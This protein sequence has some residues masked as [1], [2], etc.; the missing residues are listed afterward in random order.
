[1][2]NDLFYIVTEDNEW[3][4]AIKLIQKEDASGYL[5]SKTYEKYLNGIRDCLFMQFDELGVYAGPWTSG[6]IYKK[7]YVK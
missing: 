7:D 2:E 6:T 4:M 5:Q 3:S 1:M